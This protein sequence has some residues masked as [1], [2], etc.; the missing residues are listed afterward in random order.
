MRRDISNFHTLAG[1][2]SPE[3]SCELKLVALLGTGTV[4]GGLSNPVNG[5]TGAVAFGP[6]S[7]VAVPQGAMH[8][9]EN[10]SCTEEVILQ[11]AQSGGVSAVNLHRRKWE[12]FRAR[13]MI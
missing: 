1:D 12:L 6:G 9:A 13:F 7:V 8:S 4:V 10:P 3:R 11:Q 5:R 2:I